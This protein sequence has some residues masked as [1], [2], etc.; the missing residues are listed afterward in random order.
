MLSNNER[1]QMNKIFPQLK[2][3]Y[4]DTFGLNNKNLDDVEISQFIKNEVE[5]GQALISPAEKVEKQK[6][7]T[8]LRQFKKAQ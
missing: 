1:F 6:I 3:K 4:S 7:S 5:S 2:K 8:K